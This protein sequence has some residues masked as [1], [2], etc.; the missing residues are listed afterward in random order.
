[1][2]FCVFDLSTPNFVFSSIEGTGA[3]FKGKP[4][5]KVVIND[6]A[7][8]GDKKYDIFIGNAEFKGKQL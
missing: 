6:P 1:M 3:E 8:T 4:I 2:F 5:A 7:I